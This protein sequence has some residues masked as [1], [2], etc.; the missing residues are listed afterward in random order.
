MIAAQGGKRARILED[1][2]D[3]EEAF[4]AL[5]SAA[6]G[7]AAADPFAQ[8]TH[9]LPAKQARHGGCAHTATAAAETVEVQMAAEGP[10]PARRGD[11]MVFVSAPSRPLCCSSPAF[12]YHDCRAG[13]RLLHLLTY[14]CLYG[15]R[16]IR[17]CG[18]A[19]R[20]RFNT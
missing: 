1:D 2:S 8:P 12:C 20:P 7:A 18:F 5:P 15:F 3:M 11:C 6:P 14:F 10:P 19:E 9:P 4:E 13:F 17:H 16:R